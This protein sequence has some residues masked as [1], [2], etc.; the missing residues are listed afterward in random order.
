MGLTTAPVTDA[1]MLMELAAAL[2]AATSPLM[3]T[4]AEL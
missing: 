1:A 2:V 4:A 3:D